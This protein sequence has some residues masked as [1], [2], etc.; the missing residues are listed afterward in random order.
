MCS[1]CELTS[2]GIRARLRSW[3]GGG[4]SVGHRDPLRGQ[5]RNVVSLQI[6]G[7]GGQWG[8]RVHCNI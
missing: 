5:T 7:E 4:Q 8:V 3:R 6:V 2:D 1:T